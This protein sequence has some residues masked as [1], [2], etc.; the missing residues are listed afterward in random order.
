MEHIVLDQNWTLRKGFLDSLSMIQNDP[1]MRVDLPHDAMI[2]TKVSPNAA[3]KY[4]SGYFEGVMCN[5]TKQILIPMDWN[6]ECIGLQFDGI[7]MHATIE[8]NGCKVAEHHYGYSPF[9]VD[10]LEFSPV[11]DGIPD[12][13]CSEVLRF[14]MARRY[15]LLQMEFS[16]RQVEW[17]KILHLLMRKLKWSMRLRIT[18]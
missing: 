4:D 2:S 16:F 11:P 12:A 10:I 15:I 13:A 9:Y 6:E 3:A 17:M 7:M 18:K 8:I 14:V 1:G 5:Y